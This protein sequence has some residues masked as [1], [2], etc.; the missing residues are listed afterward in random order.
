MPSS[1]GW[2]VHDREEEDRV[3]RMLAALHQVE[4][5]DEL[6]FGGIRDSLSDLLFP[7][8]STIQTRLRYFLIVPWCYREVESRRV[9]APRFGREVADLE[10]RLIQPLLESGDHAGAF[11]AQRGQQIR[12]LPSSVY[13][14][15]LQQWGIR[16]ERVSQ[17]EY[18]RNVDHYYRVSAARE[19]EDGER[20]S[21]MPAMIWH[22]SL[23]EPPKGFPAR[24]DLVMRP[25]D[26]QFL[27]DR[28]RETQPDSLLTWLAQND[29]L[30]RPPLDEPFPWA[31]PSFARFPQPTRKIL[32]HARLV[33]EVTWGAGLLYNLLLARLP[34]PTP[35]RRAWQQNVADQRQADLRR[36]RRS[37][38]R[39]AEL[40]T[41]D[42]EELGEICDAV[43]G[44]QITRPTRIF[45][46]A[47][48]ERVIACRGH[49]ESDELSTRLVRKREEDLKGRSRRSRFHNSTMLATWGGEAGIGRLTFRWP[50]VQALLND[51][52]TG[53]AAEGAA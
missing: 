16:R 34:A 4:A 10:R 8:T 42:L 21:R 23:P 35:A 46:R 25:M 33:S 15:G 17:G 40:R 9:R 14:S 19:A 52:G 44:H 48:V 30:G 5:R 7:G 27:I 12:R 18:H 37:V 11:G 49:V 45:L 29:P 41:W 6:G 31:H 1:I 53:L 3:N 32:G 43:P 51:I 20:I 22:P 26:V 36:W 24:L 28:L 2:V 38:L 47:W 50:T 13:W 39:L